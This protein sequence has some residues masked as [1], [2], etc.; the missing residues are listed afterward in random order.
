MTK[1]L[2]FYLIISVPLISLAEG[3]LTGV[4][5]IGTLTPLER[6]GAYGNNL[7]LTESEAQKLAAQA[8]AYNQRA[9][10]DSDPERRAPKSG[11]RVGGYNLS[12]IHI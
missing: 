8:E 6:P 1:H 3:D 2:L 9:N 12:L 5:D 10:Q 4:Y 11:G 7:Y